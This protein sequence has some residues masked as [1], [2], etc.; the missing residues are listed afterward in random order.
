M[1]FIIGDLICTVM[2]MV[3]LIAVLFL[4]FIPKVV[5]LRRGE[6][7]SKRILVVLMVAAMVFLG[8]YVT[9]LYLDYQEW[10][11]TKTLD[12]GLNITAPEGISG[13]VY[14]PITVNRDLRDA[15]AV[16]DGQ[17]TI[18]IVEVK[19][20]MALRV[21]F[22]GNVTIGGGLET[23]GEFADFELTLVDTSHIPGTR[24]YWF[25]RVSDPNDTVEV[26]LSMEYHSVYRDEWYYATHQLD[27]G[28]ASLK[29]RWGYQNWYYG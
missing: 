29:V 22:T 3:G 4:L 1:V 10:T 15:V 17:A 25:G 26:D 19:Y 24:W 6:N 16:Q 5:E 2:V 11:D 7:G 28:W 23:Q 13:T 21:D 27:D 20:G 12:Y 14:V 18:T 8:S 9:W